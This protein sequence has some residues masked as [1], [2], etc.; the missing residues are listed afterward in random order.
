MRAG[1]PQASPADRQEGAGFAFAIFGSINGG[2]PHI[3][4]DNRGRIKAL[5][6]TGVP[7]ED[8]M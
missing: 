4:I 8:P 2:P 6:P 5:V 7:K 1:G 3:T